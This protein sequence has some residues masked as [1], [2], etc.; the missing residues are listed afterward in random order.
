MSTSRMIMGIGL[1]LCVLAVF[2]APVSA[3]QMQE[4]NGKE[5]VTGNCFGKI[6]GA[7]QTQAQYQN[8]GQIRNELGSVLGDYRLQLLDLRIGAADN[9]IATF[10]EN[11]I[12]MTEARGVL[13]EIAA[14]RDDLAAAF[15][16]ED[17]EA[18]TAAYDELRSL[19]KELRDAIK[20]AV[21]AGTQEEASL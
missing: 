6:A 18:V 8:R 5:I 13:D 11:G 21:R 1:A 3:G 16:A 12:D 19:W 2:T 4:P 10:E 17:R 15:A 7:D 9:V 14:L 20:S